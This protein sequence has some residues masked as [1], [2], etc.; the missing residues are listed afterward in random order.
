M[1]IHWEKKPQ[2]SMRQSLIELSV[3]GVHPFRRERPIAVI[4]QRV[5][6]LRRGPSDRTFAATAKFGESE[7]TLRGQSCHLMLA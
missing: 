6:M 7:L 3:S 1:G 5:A 4:Q 2:S